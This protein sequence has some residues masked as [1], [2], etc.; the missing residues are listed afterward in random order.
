MSLAQQAALDD[1]AQHLY[2][3]LP[4]K[5]HPY[6]D[7]SLSF[8]GVAKALGLE[9]YWPGESKQPAIRTLLGSVI[10]ANRDLTSLIL[11]IVERSITY[12]KRSNPLTREQIDRLNEILLRVGYKIPELH[13]LGFL[14]R[15]PRTESQSDAKAASTV[16]DS[17]ALAAFQKRLLKLSELDPHPR[18]YAFQDFL[19]ELFHAYGLAPRGAF[20]LTGEEI[21]GSFSLNHETYLLEAKWQ[22]EQVGQSA[23]ITFQ[24]KVEGKAQWSR[25]LFVSYCG[26]SKDGLE[27]FASGRRTSIICMDGLDLSQSLSG[28]MDL[29]KVLT[30]KSRRAAETNRA[31]VPVNEMFTRV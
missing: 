19:S 1:L 26:F 16:V 9:R 14:S 7:Q 24:G 18:G 29:M 11:K 28:N 2:D 10:A 17:Q 13:E 12:R 23:L 4:G 30:V 25:G 31:F 5:A 27:G 6:A 22:N 3:F 21:D 20:R 8:P 15:L